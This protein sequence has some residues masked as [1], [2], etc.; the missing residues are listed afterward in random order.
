VAG[1]ARRFAMDEFL[2]YLYEDLL[3]DVEIFEIIFKAAKAAS[4]S[5][6]RDEIIAWYKENIVPDDDEE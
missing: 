1:G 4:K 3:L 5:A 2:S 6:A